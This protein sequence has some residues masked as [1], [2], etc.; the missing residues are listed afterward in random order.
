ME[1]LKDLRSQKGATQKNV[2]DYLGITQQAYA[3][4]EGGKREPDAEMLLK[5]SEYFDVSVDY[6]LGRKLKDTSAPL[7]DKVLSFALF[8]R[9]DIDD[10]VLEDVKRYAA[11][12]EQRKKAEKDGKTE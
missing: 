2:A 12:V 3:N 4:Y 1:R 11:F 7:D 9:T 5:V 8:G 10:D 6:L